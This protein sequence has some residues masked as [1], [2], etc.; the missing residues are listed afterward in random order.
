MKNAILKIRKSIYTYKY[1]K[2]IN[3]L[4]SRTN[5]FSFCVY[6]RREISGWPLGIPTKFYMHMYCTTIHKHI[7]IKYGC[8][9]KAFHSLCVRPQTVFLFLYNI[10]NFWIDS[11]KLHMKRELYS[12]WIML[13]TRFFLYTFLFLNKRA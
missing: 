7:C 8:T 2:Y 4:Y 5:A 12:M 10:L 1:I 13:F 11:A 3:K 9:N 6:F